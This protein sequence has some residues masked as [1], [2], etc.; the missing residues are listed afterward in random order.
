[1]TELLLLQLVC[2]GA[3]AT[4]AGCALIYGFLAP[5]WEDRVGIGFLSTK[6]AFSF[7]LLLTALGFHGIQVP[8][9]LVVLAFVLVIVTVNIGV[10]WNIIY[11]QLIEGR[12]GKSRRL[13]WRLGRRRKVEG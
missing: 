6:I 8:L 5:W 7:I 9:W 10:T 4:L 3:F 1:M 13:K 2:W 11:K 12:A